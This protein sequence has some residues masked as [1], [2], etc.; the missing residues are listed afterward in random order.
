LHPSQ[1]TI[2]KRTYDVQYLSPAKS[3]TLPTPS[4]ANFSCTLASFTEVS[5]HS[6]YIP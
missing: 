4:S 1:T 5:L 2:T 6:D 3:W